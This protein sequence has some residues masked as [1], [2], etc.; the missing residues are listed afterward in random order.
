VRKTMLISGIA[1]ASALL[2]GA[3]GTDSG[4]TSMPGMQSSAPA[5]GAGQQA[6]HNPDDVTFV[7]QM[8]PHHSQALDMAKLVSGHSTNP[9]IIDLASRVEKAQDPEIQQMQGWLSNWNASMPGMSTG[10]MPGMSD[11]S[12]PGMSGGSMPGMMSADEMK[13]LG[14]AKGAEF[15]KM[16]LDM[17]V[18]HHQGAVDMAKTELGKGASPEAK[19]LAQKIID[20]QQAEI[21]EMQGM[22]SQS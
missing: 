10:T 17:M 22:L 7:Q 13:Q 14:Q 15:D 12:M 5:A 6:G 20:A 21:T 18:K 8:M 11:G 9:R 4:S 2:L 19:V 3:C 16:W 1:L